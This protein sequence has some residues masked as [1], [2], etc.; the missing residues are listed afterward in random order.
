[1]KHL[2][3]NALSIAGSFH[4]IKINLFFMIP[5][6]SQHHDF[7]NKYLTQKRR[8]HCFLEVHF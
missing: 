3:K 5:E 2:L 7:K 6:L 8:C 1:M 4:C